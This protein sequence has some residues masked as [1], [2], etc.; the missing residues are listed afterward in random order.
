MPAGELIYRLFMSFYGL[1]FPAYVWICM[2]PGRGGESGLTPG[3]LRAMMLGILV[4]A[5]MYWMGF[6]EDQL[7]WLVPGV[8]A[9]LLS[10]FAVPKRSR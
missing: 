3:K 8:A 5:P 10:R 1:V 2:V 7:V 6:I 4:A 9:V